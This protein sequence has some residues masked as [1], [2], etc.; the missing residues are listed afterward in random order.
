M[1]R[2]FDGHKNM[3]ITRSLLVLLILLTANC[4]PHIR[5]N[6]VSEPNFA[7]ANDGT[8]LT[9]A[10][11][12]DHQDNNLYCVLRTSEH[13][14][15][16]VQLL[17]TD[18]GISDYQLGQALRYM[19]I[20]DYLISTTIAYA[21]A[22]LGRAIAGS[23]YA[24]KAKPANVIPLFKGVYV[25]GKAKPVALAITGISIAG[26]VVYRVIRGRQE[27]ESA[28]AQIEAGILGVAD[29]YAFSIGPLL[30]LLERGDRA[31]ALISSKKVLRVSDKKME[32]VINRVINMQQ[33]ESGTCDHLKTTHN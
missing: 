26:L 24:K 3:Q 30:E 29:R 31:K 13:D 4:G 11:A 16:Q 19:S 12:T 20:P 33:K 32:K 23:V 10:L 28:R 17:T 25:L 1:K 6:Q 27:G 18:G 15:S 21:T 5:D 8:M 7:K 2:L 22:F 9:I 14:A